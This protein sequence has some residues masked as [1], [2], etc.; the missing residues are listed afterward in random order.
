MICG[1]LAI[2]CYAVFFCSSLYSLW[3]RICGDLSQTNEN[4]YLTVGKGSLVLFLVF[5]LLSLIEGVIRK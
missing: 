3:R 4:I 5:G 2:A 1:A